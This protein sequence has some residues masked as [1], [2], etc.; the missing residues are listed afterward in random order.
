M[1]PTLPPSPVAYGS[2]APTLERLETAI[3]Q[4]MRLVDVDSTSGREGPV[5]PLVHAVAAELGLSARTMPVAAGRDNVLVGADDPAAVEVLLCTHLDTVPPFL[6]ARREATAL[7]GRGSCDAKGIAVAMLHAL[8]IARQAASGAA[9]AA[10]LLVVG[11]ETDHAG[12]RAA[13][14]TGLFRPRHVILGEPCGTAPAIGQKGL[15]K[16]RC[17]ARGRAGHSA[18]PETGASAIHQLV[19]ALARLR[20]TDLPCDPTLGETTVNIGEIHG[21]V[22][23]NVFAP[24]AHATLVIRCAAPVDA[25]YAAA[26]SRL[27]PHVEVTELS[28]AEPH[29]FETYGEVAGPAVPFNTDASYLRLLGAPVALFGPGDMRCA[30]GE[31]EH[32]AFSELAAGIEAYARAIV[33]LS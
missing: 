14:E 13:L 28:R 8:A 11:E 27:G 5:V 1:E 30:H 7:W 2:L 31:R 12:A 16:L 20:A 26:R 9:R 4:L 24:D 15:I 3:V 23:P 22:A 17:E 19:D 32:L 21:G 33:R 25:V 6:P 18:Y 29:D 10:C